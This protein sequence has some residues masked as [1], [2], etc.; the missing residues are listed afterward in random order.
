[1]ITVSGAARGR[2]GKW[3]H[4]SRRAGL[5][6]AS[7]HFIQAFKKQV[8]QQKFRPKC[9]KN[10]YFLE[11]GCKIAAA[12]GGSVLEPPLASGGWRLC[13]QSPMSLLPLMILKLPLID[14][15]IVAII[16]LSI[17][18]LPLTDQ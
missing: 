13:L 9:Q 10:A 17:S 14:I 18:L 5:G 4:A 2:E 12:A 6:G 15:D 11:K 1:V 3:G 7:T 8:F 16:V